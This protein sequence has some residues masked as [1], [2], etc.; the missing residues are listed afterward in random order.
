MVIRKCDKCGKEINNEIYTI[1]VSRDWTFWVP[2]IMGYNHEIECCRN[3][4]KEIKK[5]IEEIK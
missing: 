4:M 5:V 1:Y 3:C 2:N